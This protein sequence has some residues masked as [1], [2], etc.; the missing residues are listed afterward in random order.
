M[1]IVLGLEPTRTPCQGALPTEPHCMSSEHLIRREQR[2]TSGL[3]VVGC[4]PTGEGHHVVRS[5][6]APPECPI[7]KQAMNER[8]RETLEKLRSRITM[9]GGQRFIHHLSDKCI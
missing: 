5:Q 2:Q 6:G 4:L 7:V 3:T 1:Q 8:T 9:G